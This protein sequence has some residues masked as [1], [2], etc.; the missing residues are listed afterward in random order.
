MFSV[1]GSTSKRS[2]LAYNS[3]LTEIYDT[4]KYKDDMHI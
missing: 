1:K 2:W 4:M 3:F